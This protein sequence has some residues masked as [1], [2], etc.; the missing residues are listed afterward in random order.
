[1]YDNGSI[2]ILS[3]I[4]RLIISFYHRFSPW[5]N[6]LAPAV[7]GDQ[8]GLAGVGLSLSRRFK[9]WKR[10][11]VDMEYLP[12]IVWY[13]YW[14]SY[15]EYLFIYWYISVEYLYII[16]CIYIYILVYQWNINIYGISM[17]IYCWSVV[18]KI[19]II[20]HHIWGIT[21]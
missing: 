7:A 14:Y 13:I 10:W 1:M 2:L 15:W 18:S 21:I 4:I 6:P 9:R 5:M 11:F 17:Y 8:A 12:F 20:F 16:I 19:W 3:H